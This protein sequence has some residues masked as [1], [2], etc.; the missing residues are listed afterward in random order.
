MVKKAPLKFV[1]KTSS[2]AASSTSSKGANSGT[3]ALT[4][5]LK[6]F[7]EYCQ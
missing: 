4:N 2:K 1:L 7:R 6:R 3:P 5:S